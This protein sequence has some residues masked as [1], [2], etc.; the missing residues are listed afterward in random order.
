MDDGK[1]T[2]RKD[3]SLQTHTSQLRG[4]PEESGDQVWIT[5]TWM[6][7]KIVYQGID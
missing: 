4:G 5:Y 1:E 6:F 3:T 7:K 2:K